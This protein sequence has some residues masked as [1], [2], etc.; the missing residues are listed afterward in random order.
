MP[1]KLVVLIGGT[2]KAFKD[3]LLVFGGDAF[4]RILYPEKGVVIAHRGTEDDRI[5]CLGVSNGVLHQIH[6]RLREA[7]AIATNGA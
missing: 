3:A 6:H 7:L 5:L 1:F 4:T 2:G